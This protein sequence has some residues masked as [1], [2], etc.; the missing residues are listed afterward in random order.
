ML[1]R[2]RYIAESRPTVTH[3]K[4]DRNY[5]CIYF[6]QKTKPSTYLFTMYY[7]NVLE[8]VGILEFVLKILKPRALQTYLSDKFID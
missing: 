2:H 3:E 7:L 1:C 6:R 4:F 8:F 5:I